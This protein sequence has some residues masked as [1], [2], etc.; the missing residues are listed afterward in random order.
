MKKPNVGRQNLNIRIYLST[1]LG[2]STGSE[3]VEKL[4]N[5]IFI[6]IVEIFMEIWLGYL[7]KQFLMLKAYFSPH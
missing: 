6:E 3:K 5:Y 7:N 4:H 2:Y 1:F